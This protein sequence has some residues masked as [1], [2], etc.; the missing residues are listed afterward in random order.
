MARTAARDAAFRILFERSFGG[1]GGVDGVAAMTDAQFS[2]EDRAY[3]GDVTE[4]CRAV[5]EDLDDFIAKYARGWD[6]DR[7]ARTDLCLLRLA[8]YEILHREDIPA[9]VSV[10]EAVE[11]AHIYSSDEAPAFINGVLGSLVR[12]VGKE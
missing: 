1:E 11:L 5:E 8:A 2:V 7:L 3:I 4:G 6:I 12:E 10:N 9:S